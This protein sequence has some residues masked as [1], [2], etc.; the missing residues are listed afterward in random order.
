LLL[1][2]EFPK[3]FPV[4]C[5]LGCVQV[6]DCLPQEEYLEIYPNGEIA[7]PYVLVFDYPQALPFNLPIQS[8]P[9]ICK[10]TLVF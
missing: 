8:K 3:N 6:L 7:D 1:D 4:G 10:F 2:C 5:L 9:K